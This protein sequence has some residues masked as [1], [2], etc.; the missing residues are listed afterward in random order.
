MIE[1]HKRRMPVEFCRKADLCAREH[2]LLI[3]RCRRVLFPF[4]PF[5][6]SSHSLGI[7]SRNATGGSTDT[8]RRPGSIEKSCVFNVGSVDRLV[9]HGGI[10][11]RRGGPPGDTK[12]TRQE[13]HNKLEVAVACTKQLLAAIKSNH[14]CHVSRH[15]ICWCGGGRVM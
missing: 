2:L 3:I 6:R 7:G 15:R 1:L 5:T 4:F 9:D 11:A 14:H 10:P 13:N 8:S 12:R